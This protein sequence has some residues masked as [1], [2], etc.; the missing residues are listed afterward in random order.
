[1]W[2]VTLVLVL[3]GLGG[4][5]LVI[6]QGSP[7]SGAPDLG[8]SAE[9]IVRHANEL[10][11]AEKRMATAADE[12]LA[13]A[14]LAFAQFMARTDR[15][16]HEAD[17]STP[18]QR[19][20]RHNYAFCMVSEN[21]AFVRSSDGFTAEELARRFV[22]GWKDSA[23]H[24]ANLLDPDATQTGAGVAYSERTGRYYAVQLFGRPKSAMFEVGIVNR[25]DRV[26]VY[27]IGARTF[28]LPPRVRRV[29]SR[30]RADTFRLPDADDPQHAAIR[31]SRSTNLAIVGDG[32]SLRWE[33]H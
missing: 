29:H 26:V 27:R 31:P 11:A 30:C 2:R 4:P 14:A 10:R 16:G 5:A 13:R 22:Q 33:T 3:A 28:E 7:R 20:E 19:A 9:L 1:M 18:A 23:G 25:T 12:R 32:A 17:G 8:R 6:A 24:R 15:Y 21:I